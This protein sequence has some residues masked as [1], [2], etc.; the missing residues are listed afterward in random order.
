MYPVKNR[1]LRLYDGLVRK[2]NNFLYLPPFSNHE[3]MKTYGLHS[4]PITTRYKILSYRMEC[5]IPI[6]FPS[7]IRAIRS[8]NE[9]SSIYGVETTIEIPCFSDAGA[10]P[11][12]LFWIQDPPL[13]SVHPETIPP[14]Y[15]LMR[16]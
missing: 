7:C 2:Q 3:A 1:T 8:H 9:A 12:I 4:Q 16:N 10:S 15:V 11:K 13:L 6:N 5:L 14:A